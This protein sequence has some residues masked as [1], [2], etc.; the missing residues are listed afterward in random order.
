MTQLKFESIC[1]VG[2]YVK[3]KSIFCYKKSIAQLHLIYALFLMS[4][5]FQHFLLL[6]L[7][8]V[9]GGYGRAIQVVLMMG[10]ESNSPFILTLKVFLRPN[11]EWNF[12]YFKLLRFVIERKDLFVFVLVQEARLVLN[13][14]LLFVGL[15]FYL[16]TTIEL[17]KTRGM[18]L[19]RGTSILLLSFFYFIYIGSWPDFR[20][21]EVLLQCHSLIIETASFSRFF[22]GNFIHM[23]T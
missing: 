6:I 23:G 14:G 2:V 3:F 16:L 22:L 21:P 13:Y 19:F 20:Q 12:L 11:L 7:Y 1:I 8:V 17:I 15:S 18:S 9:K 4:Y 10:P 5:L